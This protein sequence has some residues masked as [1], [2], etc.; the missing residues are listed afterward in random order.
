MFQTQTLYFALSA[1]SLGVINI[2]LGL[3][4]MKLKT[5]NLVLVGLVELLVLSQLVIAVVALVGGVTAKGSLFEFFGYLLVALIVPVIGAVLAIAEKSKNAN[6]IL[7]IAGA[8]IAIMLY[9][10]WVIWSGQ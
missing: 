2:L 8:T 9:R 6:L 4:G 1:L 10:M 5:F 3:F 7:G